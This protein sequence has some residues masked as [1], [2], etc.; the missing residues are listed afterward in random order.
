MQE[1]LRDL[2]E[3]AEMAQIERVILRATIMSL[4]ADEKWLSGRLKDG[5]EFCAKMEHQMVSIQEE[6]ERLKRS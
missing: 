1:E 3:G 4:G 6:L 2:R 5:R